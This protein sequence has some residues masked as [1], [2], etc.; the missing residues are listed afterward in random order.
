MSIQQQLPEGRKKRRRAQASQTE[1]GKPSNRTI[2][3]EQRNQ[4]LLARYYYWTEIR[5]VRF[6]DTIKI[7]T[8]REFFVEDRTITNALLDLSPYLEN[9]YKE[10]LTT[11][12][13]KQ[14][15]PSFDWSKTEI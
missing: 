5:R 7:L 15:Y 14:K 4:L 2:L 1:Q 10:K 9:L 6:D 11:R 12:K 13:L 8:Q 3:I